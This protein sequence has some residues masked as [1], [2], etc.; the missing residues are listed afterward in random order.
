[1]PEGLS[2]EQKTNWHWT[3][4]DLQWLGFSWGPD[5]A[6]GSKAISY[7]SLL[8]TDHF[9]FQAFDK[10]MTTNWQSSDKGNSVYDKAWIGYDFGEGLGRQIQKIIIKADSQYVVKD[11]LIQN[12]DDAVAW[13]D[14]A[15]GTADK[16]INEITFSATNPARYWRVL[17]KSNVARA[18]D[19]TN[20][21]V[22]QP[23]IIPEIEM[24]EL[25]ELDLT[26][27]PIPPR[28]LMAEKQGDTFIL[29]WHHPDRL[30]FDKRTAS[31]RIYQ[32]G[33]FLKAVPN[34]LFETVVDNLRDDQ[35]YEFTVTS[36][37]IIGKESLPSEP[38]RITSELKLVYNENC[39]HFGT[40]ISSGDD[41][42][43]DEAFVHE[44]KYGFD[45]LKKTFWLPHSYTLEESVVDAPMTRWIGY[46]FGY[47]SPRHIRQIVLTQ[48]KGYDVPKVSV[49]SSDDGETWNDIVTDELIF[50]TNNAPVDHRFLA[51]DIGD[52]AYTV[53]EQPD[54]LIKAYIQ[55]P[56]SQPAR[57]WRV[58]ANALGDTYTIP[59]W[60][61]HEVEMMEGSYQSELIGKLPCALD[62]I[63]IYYFK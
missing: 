33:L 24:I 21:E 51:V 60:H 32:N 28:R 40:P 50:F 3:I 20:A 59:E 54:E 11:V 30:S 47:E 27:T 61:V 17:A 55:L 18:G 41:T 9:D 58:Q 19:Q 36:V 39:T 1:M 43:E 4:A 63:Y 62:N 35:V 10:D 12:S 13:N 15:V 46:D 44:A 49:Q 34:Y 22:S 56:Y 8:S 42:Q 26:D 2:D 6:F 25:K 52:T 48:G 23:W 57:Y 38:Y 53:Q 5:V 29:G 14:V 7:N 16:Q 31:F 45:G 37:D